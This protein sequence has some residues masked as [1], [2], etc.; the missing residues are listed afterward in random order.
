MTESQRG[1]FLKRISSVGWGTR[2]NVQML[3]GAIVTTIRDQVADGAF[4][5]TEMREVVAFHD[6]NEELWRA[7]MVTNPPIPPAAMIE[8]LHELLARCVGPLVGFRIQLERALQQA[9]I[10]EKIKRHRNS[11]G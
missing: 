2:E 10:F 5:E 7:T 8:G 9:E 4:D 11:E 6:A 3:I 1:D